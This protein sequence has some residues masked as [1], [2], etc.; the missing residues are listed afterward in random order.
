MKV[1]PTASGGA[2]GK[3][4]LSRSNTPVDSATIGGGSVS[5]DMESPRSKTATPVPAPVS[6]GKIIFTN[7]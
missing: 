6:Q 7:C 1:L 3:S 4:T 5:S 2:G